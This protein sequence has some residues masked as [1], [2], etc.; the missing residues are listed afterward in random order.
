MKLKRTISLI[1]VLALILNVI[2]VPQISANITDGEKTEFIISEKFESGIKSE[3][4]ECR[5]ASFSYGEMVL[6]GSNSEMYIKKELSGANR[7]EAEFDLKTDIAVDK[8]N[9]KNGAYVGFLLE[10]AGISPDDKMRGV[11]LI[12]NADK[13]SLWISGSGIG[14]DEALTSDKHAISASYSIEISKDGATIMM[15]GEELFDISVAGGTLTANCGEESISATGFDYVGRSHYFGFSVIGEGSAYIDNFSFYGYS[16]TAASEEEVNSLKE[17]EAELSDVI[18]S[19]N[20]DEGKYLASSVSGENIEELGEELREAIERSDS[21]DDPLLS[22]EAK[23]LITKSEYALSEIVTTA[24]AEEYEQTLLGYKEKVL[25]ADS[26][27]ESKKAE[28]AGKIDEALLITGEEGIT[29]SKLDDVAEE[30]AEEIVTASDDISL[31]ATRVSESMTEITEEKFN[32]LFTQ[33]GNELASMPYASYKGFSF[34]WVERY[35]LMLKENYKTYELGVTVDMAEIERQTINLRQ[36]EGADMWEDEDIAPNILGTHGVI[37]M[38]TDNGRNAYLAVRDGLYNA[39]AEDSRTYIEITIPEECFDGNKIR[40]IVCDYNDY[41]EIYAEKADG[42]RVIIASVTFDAILSAED[43]MVNNWKWVRSTCYTEGTLK[44]ELTGE[45]VTFSEKKIP[46]SEGSYVGFAIRGGKAFIKDIILKSDIVTENEVLVISDKTEIKGISVTTDKDSLKVGETLTVEVEADCTNLKVAGKNSYKDGTVK[47]TDKAEFSTLYGAL[48]YKN[49]VFTAV[50]AGS[51]RIKADSTLNGKSVSAAKDIT[52]TADGEETVVSG[53]ITAAEIVNAE[54]FASL[55]A[56]DKLVP[57]IRY[58]LENGRI[59]TVKNKVKYD[60]VIA[61][62]DIL[63]EDNGIITAIGEGVT[64]FYVKL[65]WDNG[66]ESGT[67]D[68]LPVFSEV[69][70]DKTYG[71]SEAA[72]A[73]LLLYVYEEEPSESET[74]KLYETA[75]K[76]G[77]SIDIS[78]TSRDYVNNEFDILDEK[79]AENALIAYKK[80]IA[81][82]KLKSLLKEKSTTSDKIKTFLFM[83]DNADILGFGVKDYNKLSPSKQTGAIKDFMSE[84][85]KAETPSSEKLAELF[86]DAVDDQKGSGGGGGSAESVKDKGVIVGGGVAAGTNAPVVNKAEPFSDM[87]SATWANEAVLSLSELEIINGYPD[88][89]FRPGNAVTRDEFVKMMVLTAGYDI[90]GRTGEFTDVAFD[91][92]QNPYV[93][94]ALHNGLVAGMG[95]RVFGLGMNITRQDLV[96]IIYRYLEKAGIAK[97]EGKNVNFAD[98]DEI[99]DYAIDAVASLAELGIINGR[100]GNVFAPGDTA[101]RAECAL[102]L[103]RVLKL[104][105]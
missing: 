83:E 77:L 16:K 74:E 93:A 62:E 69:C 24:K 88:G 55:E 9:E 97:V 73:M 10:Q 39:T 64:R 30:I 75:G 6:S 51:D 42:S 58:T 29:V 56:G 104:F 1:F 65:Y 63:S 52:V 50:S 27:S 15:D 47:V 25:E 76:I 100:D 79:D 71:K 26:L 46:M 19:V 12:A 96:L 33:S 44:N 98:K 102:M 92:W 38:S 36:I 81:A 18:E 8:S 5:G 85:K 95:D 86:D 78:E 45:E 34:S 54:A 68:S 49:G 43:I 20:A 23:E 13:V 4:I 17:L 3:N 57:I 37:L 80:G 35:G 32:G 91:A 2:S 7:Y 53:K 22:S 41:I 87:E 103:Y 28:I 70:D 72:A 90:S 66:E 101:T 99:A 11:W 31:E 105:K 14:I 21:A 40:Y 67:F 82:D 89:T 94:S 48:S 61:D 60:I 59:I 84:A